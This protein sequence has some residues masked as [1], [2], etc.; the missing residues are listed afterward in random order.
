M[1]RGY[2]SMG[3]KS[4]DLIRARTTRGSTQTD[5][6]PAN[7]S[8]RETFSRTG[9]S[10]VVI[11]AGARPYCSGQARPGGVLGDAGS[12]PQLHDPNPKLVCVRAVYEDWSASPCEGYTR[13]HSRAQVT[14]AVGPARVP[15]STAR[16]IEWSRTAKKT[17]HGSCLPRAYMEAIVQVPRH[18]TA[19]RV[20]D[21]A[22]MQTRTLT[23]CFRAPVAGSPG[24][25]RHMRVAHR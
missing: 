12:L 16:S 9:E 11:M 24:A 18:S 17:E 13:D 21:L 23:F 19:H 5:L 3:K 15:S 10:Q 6:P 2:L 1:E 14:G 4:P 20:G 25:P 7:Q 8:S 22:T